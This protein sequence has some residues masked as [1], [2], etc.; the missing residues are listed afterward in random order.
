MTNLN[1]SS[2]KKD[3]V[4]LNVGVKSSSMWPLPRLEDL[5]DYVP[6]QWRAQLFK[7]VY[8]KF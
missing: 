2:Y 5:L 7:L 4:Q 1:R 6:K 3:K 8:S